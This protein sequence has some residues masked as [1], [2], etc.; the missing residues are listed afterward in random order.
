VTA[1]FS[2]A[3]LGVT[4]AMNWDNGFRQ[5]FAHPP[6]LIPDLKNAQSATWVDRNRST[7]VS[8]TQ[9]FNLILERQVG[10]SMSFTA[11]YVGNVGRRLSHGINWDETDPKYLNLGDLLSKNILDPAVVAAGFKEPFPGFAALFGARGTLAQALKR[12]P[13]FTSVGQAGAFFGSSNYH[14]LQMSGTRRMSKGL[15]FTMAYTFSKSINDTEVYGYG[16]GAMDYFNRKLDRSLASLDQ[17]H[18]LSVS[19]IYEL[20]FG[21]GQKHLTRGIA[22]TFLGG[23]KIT[24]LQIYS[25]GTPLGFNI[26]NN[27]PIGNASQRPNVVSPN[28]RSNVS[29]GAFDPAK[30]L[31]LNP[32]ALA[33]PA[34]YTFGN[35]P[36]NSGVR[37]PMYMNESLGLLK[38]TRWKERFNWQFRFEATNPLNRVVFGSPVTNF[39]ASSFGKITSAQG[40]RRLTLGTKFYF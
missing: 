35:A 2:S 13:Q 29:A 39:S 9:Q 27:L 12:W 5:D 18:T 37:S 31:W 24:G 8:Y 17:P 19:Y 28:L 23:W 34:A 7:I 33:I 36:R 14:S 1:S 32:A 15:M 22:S 6:Q 26:N 20:P 25:S 3:D 30:D 10:Q 40:A 4:P 38:D 11:G 21:P 16:T